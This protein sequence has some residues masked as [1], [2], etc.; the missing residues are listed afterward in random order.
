MIFSILAFR[1]DSDAR[2]AGPLDAYRAGRVTLSNAIGTGCGGRQ[3]DL[4]L[5]ARDDPLL[6]GRGADPQQRRPTCAASRGSGLYPGAPAGACRQGSAWRRLR[7]ARRPGLD[8]GTDRDLPARI[9][10]PTR[11]IHRP[12]DAG[13]FELSDLSSTAVSRRAIWTCAPS[14][15]PGARC[16]WC[17][18]ASPRRAARRIS[19]WN[20][21]RAGGTKD[22]WVLEA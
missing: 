11:E 22:T 21:R 8:Q 4:P 12:A 14:S 6:P 10:R 15:C 16:N 17:R 5:R 2:R 1:R 20:P 13:P 7:H 18:V 9:S 3:V 19:W